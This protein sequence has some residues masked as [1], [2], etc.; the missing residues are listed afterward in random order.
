MF[1]CLSSGGY[2]FLIPRGGKGELFVRISRG[3]KLVS[4]DSKGAEIVFFSPNS[5][6]GAGA[7]IVF[8]DVSWTGFFSCQEGWK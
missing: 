7:E 1:V 2:F 8:S 6:G 4:S 3:R 5:G